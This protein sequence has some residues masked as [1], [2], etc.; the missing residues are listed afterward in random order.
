MM[1]TLS[2]HQS[3][4]IIELKNKLMEESKLA[5]DY[6]SVE[7]D[8]TTEKGYLVESSIKEKISR[9]LEVIIYGSL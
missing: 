5:Y 2:A 8:K 4:L 7:E 6:A 1:E 3:Q 9:Q